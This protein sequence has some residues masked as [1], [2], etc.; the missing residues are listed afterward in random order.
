MQIT[1]QDH[2]IRCADWTTAEL[3]RMDLVNI[4]RLSDEALFT[5]DRAIGDVRRIACSFV[6]SA[7]DQPE[8]TFWLWH[9]GWVP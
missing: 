1:R 7:F 4:Y 3:Y 8:R 9:S 6:F 2:F 5:P